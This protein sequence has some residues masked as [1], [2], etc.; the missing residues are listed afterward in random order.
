MKTFAIMAAI[1]AFTSVASAATKS[2]GVEGKSPCLNSAYK[3][4]AGDYGSL[5]LEEYGNETCSFQKTKDGVEV[6]YS[7]FVGY[8][9]PHVNETL[10]QKTFGSGNFKITVLLNSKNDLQLKAITKTHMALS[11]DMHEMV[12][13][14]NEY[15][16][17]KAKIRAL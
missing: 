14:L 1:L 11:Q 5:W 15:P 10:A 7:L 6:T 12:A 2:S 16:A 9:N 4:S 8:I 17:L 3:G 13:F